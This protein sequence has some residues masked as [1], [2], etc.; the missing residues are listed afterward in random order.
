[1][2]GEGDFL[3]FDI[4]IKSGC[5]TLPPGVDRDGDGDR[6]RDGDLSEAAPDPE[7]GFADNIRSR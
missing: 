6:D 1:L 7:G 2:E 5:A 3:P 4:L